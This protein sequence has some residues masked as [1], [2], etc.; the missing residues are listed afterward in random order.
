MI[1]RD[2]VGQIQYLIVQ[3]GRIG[4]GEIGRANTIFRDQAGQIQLYSTRFYIVV[5]GLDQ[6]ESYK[7]KKKFLQLY[8]I[9]SYILIYFHNYIISYT[10]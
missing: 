1:F 5:A 2:Q 8:P 7:Q 3:E 4:E 10:F 6:I 9:R